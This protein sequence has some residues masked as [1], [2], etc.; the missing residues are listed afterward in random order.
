[1][2]GIDVPSTLRGQRFGLHTSLFELVLQLNLL[3]PQ[4]LQDIGL[5]GKLLPEL[6]DF[7]VTSFQL[8][9]RILLGNVAFAFRFR[10]SSGGSQ[11]T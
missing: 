9:L 6:I 8:G 3:C 4:L 2:R 5:L 7:S 11:C 1:M 10:Q